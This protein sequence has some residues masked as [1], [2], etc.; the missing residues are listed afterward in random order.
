[1]HFRCQASR[2]YG[3][4]SANS[5]SRLAHSAD[6]SP[7]RSH[8]TPVR[9]AGPHQ[10]RSGSAP[11][12]AGLPALTTPK[13]SPPTNTRFDARISISTGGPIEN[14]KL[15][16][17]NP[18]HLPRRRARRIT[19]P[20]LSTTLAMPLSWPTRRALTARLRDDKLAP[21][22]SSKQQIGRRARNSRGSARR[23]RASYRRRRSYLPSLK[24]PR[25]SPLNCSLTSQR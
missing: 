24:T 23:S 14:A 21:W 8:R 18:Q 10:P 16:G 3:A 5:S 15:S 1:M 4:A 22:A 9:L 12:R 25:H 2:S 13:T 19:Q 17:F 6:A 11:G 20:N 7:T